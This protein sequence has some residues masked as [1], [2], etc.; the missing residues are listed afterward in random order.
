MFIY[1]STPVIKAINRPLTSLQLLAN[2]GIFLLFPIYVGKP[3][4]LQCQL[5]FLLRGPVFS[6][7]VAS[8]IVKTRQILQIFSSRLSTLVKRRRSNSTGHRMQVGAALVG[9]LLHFVLLMI[10]FRFRP[11]SVLAL[12]NINSKITYLECNIGLLAAI[13]H[14]GYLF[15]LCAIC[16]FLSYKARHVPE[17]FGESRHISHC[18]G[19]ALIFWLACVP[20]FAV[21]HGRLKAIFP[22]ILLYTTAFSIQ[23]LYFFPK[24]HIV[25]FQPHRNTKEEIRRLTMAHMKKEVARR[26]ESSSF[27]PPS[28]S[29][30]VESTNAGTEPSSPKYRSIYRI[31][32]IST[33]VQDERSLQHDHTHGLD[34]ELKGISHFEGGANIDVSVDINMNKSNYKDE[35]IED[36]VGTPSFS[37]YYVNELS[38]GS[39]RMQ[40][41]SLSWKRTWPASTMKRASLLELYEQ[42]S[43]VERSLGGENTQVVTGFI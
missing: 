14:N 31:S 8:F 20:S 28:T 35:A 29:N 18:I 2:F 33:S 3:N 39:I 21:S 15:S 36:F 6:L 9:T 19:L 22:V 30:E 11:P 5:Q 4:K 25:L 24:C 16:F 41:Q 43:S 7:A 10:Y 1:R 26:I 32:S 17:N 34:V 37:S 23:F 13:P 12:D 40:E 42:Q 27:S 38:E